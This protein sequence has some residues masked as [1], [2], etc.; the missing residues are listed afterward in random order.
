MAQCSKNQG[1]MQVWLTRLNSPSW[2]RYN[3][4]YNWE[5]KTTWPHVF[6]KTS[7]MMNA[8]NF[9]WHF[10][11]RLSCFQ[12]YAVTRY[13]STVTIFFFTILEQCA[14]LKNNG[15]IG[16]NGHFLT[17]GLQLNNWWCWFLVSRV[18]KQSLWR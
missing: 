17:C 14:C 8:S 18:F 11:T 7:S 16:R 1:E 5:N 3:L 12:D 10:S 13:N 6:S 2:I 15:G 4:Q 9:I